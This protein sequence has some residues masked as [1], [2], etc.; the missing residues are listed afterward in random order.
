M[1]RRRGRT[2]PR[3]FALL[4]FG[5][6]VLALGFWLGHRSAAPAGT[7]RPSPPAP[8]PAARPAPRPA[9]AP[10]EV[11]EP[12]GPPTRARVA[13]VIDDL[14]GSLAPAARLLALGIPVTGAVLPFERHSAEVAKRLRAGGAE[15][16]VHLPMEPTGPQ[17]P[18]P[19][20]VLERWRPERIAALTESAIAAVPG[21]TGLNNH[22]GSRITAD[23]EPMRAIL[24]VVARHGLYFLDSRTT[25]E[26]RA[27]DWA[28]EAGIPA[29][30]RD[31]FLDDER[32][33]E[34]VAAQFER[35]LELARARG[36]AVAIGHPHDVTFGVLERAIPRARAAGV[37]FVPVSYLLERSENLPE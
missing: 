27:F 23:E 36:A 14:G 13:L 7:R 26:T 35:L 34:A 32:T 18:G 25:E 5:A 8:R 16:I 24:A 15:V 1:A 12:T 30:R 22:M 10:T 2:F 6:A 20:A 4:L 9:A 19:Q 11:A 3:L 28:R 29:A 37:E 17:D 31:V 21:A 33:P